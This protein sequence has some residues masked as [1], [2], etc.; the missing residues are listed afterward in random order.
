MVRVRRKDSTALLG[1]N[2]QSDIGQAGIG[3]R[4]K[5][6]FPDFL[7]N[8]KSIKRP[9]QNPTFEVRGI[10]ARFCIAAWRL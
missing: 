7:R 9:R 1:G 8:R 10:Q 4:Q 6:R 5:G 3:S 2:V